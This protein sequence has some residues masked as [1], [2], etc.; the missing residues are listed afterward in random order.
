MTNA[1][2][3]DLQVQL[4]LS[5]SKSELEKPFMKR[6]LTSKIKQLLVKTQ[7]SGRQQN[8]LRGHIKNTIINENTN[9]EYK[10]SLM[11]KL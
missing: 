5:K 8:Q 9:S 10:Q 2:N 3:G 11:H 4:A 6:A 1:K 7:P